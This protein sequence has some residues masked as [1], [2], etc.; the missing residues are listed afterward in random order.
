MAIVVALGVAG[1]LAWLA[2]RRAHADRVLTSHHGAGVYFFGSEGCLSCRPALD[3]L[4]A[5]AVVYRQF[6]WEHDEDVFER[7]EIDEVPLVWVVDSGGRVR[8]EIAGV[9]TTRQ[10]RR[11]KLQ[12][13]GE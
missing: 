1:S 3:A 9:P 6:T 7:W 13:S 11:A 12:S 8:Y 10:L 5:S 2:R 4:D